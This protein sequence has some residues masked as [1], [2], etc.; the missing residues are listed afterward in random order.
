MSSDPSLERRQRSRSQ[1]GAVF[2]NI[3]AKTRI[4]ESLFPGRAQMPRMTKLRAEQLS[5]QRVPAEAIDA[6]WKIMEEYYEA[7]AVIA[8]DSRADFAR[9]YFGESAG[10]WLAS[11]GGKV[12]GCIALRQLSAMAN[13]G[14]VKRLYVQPKYRG[15]GIA[16]ALYRSLELY[17]REREYDCLYLDTTDEM[18]AAQKFYAALAYEPTPRYNDNPQATI[19][20]RKDL[21]ATSP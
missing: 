6:A 5:V 17:A 21:R 16:A 4:A 14:E 19:Y 20:M 11:V 8:R 3:L 1:N 10:V 7:A 2:R 18:I 12:V 13:S 9:T 15:L